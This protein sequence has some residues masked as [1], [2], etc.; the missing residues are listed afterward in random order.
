MTKGEGSNMEWREWCSCFPKPKRFGGG[1]ELREVL[2]GYFRIQRL[3]HRLKGREAWVHIQYPS[4]GIGCLIDLITIGMHEL[5]YP[6]TIGVQV[7][8]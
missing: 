8:K 7:F 3:D 1:W 6:A 4:S 2:I 5:C